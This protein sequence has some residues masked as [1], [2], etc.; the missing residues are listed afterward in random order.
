MHP[1][2]AELLDYASIQRTLLGD[3]VSAVP[4][5]LRNRR[6]AADVW[7]VAEVLEHLHRTE[8]G[9]ALL[10]TARL[11]EARQAGLA[12][13]RETGSLLGS[14]D[15]FGIAEGRRRVPAPRLVHPTGALDWVL[16]LDRLAASRE[17]LR[18]AVAAGDGLALGEVVHPHPLLGSLSLYQWILFVGQHEAR[19]AAQI[20][21]AAGGA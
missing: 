1:R 20:R 16:A 8:S 10:V 13:E 11:A 18:H 5:P 7:S 15:R 12:Q 21:R 4:E 2:L 6:P 19:H 9:V 3:A 14:L 17:A